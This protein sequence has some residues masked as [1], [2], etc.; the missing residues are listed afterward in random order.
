TLD[1]GENGLKFIETV[2]K[3]GYRFVAQVRKVEG[4][5]DPVGE[6][7]IVREGLEENQA[8][9][10]QSERGLYLDLDTLERGGYSGVPAVSRPQDE[11]FKPQSSS[12]KV[13]YLLA[14]SSLVILGAVAIAYPLLFRSVSKSPPMR[15]VPFTSFPGTEGQPSFSPDGN[16]IAFAW[17]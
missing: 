13:R 10:D 3:R 14:L 11:E 12:R 7:R 16:Q 2:P 5:G 15:I 8:R 17:R 6:E 4:N 9:R 1:D